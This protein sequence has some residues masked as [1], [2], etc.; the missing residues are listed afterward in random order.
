MPLASQPR[1]EDLREARPQNTQAQRPDA[2][3]TFA[4]PNARRPQLFERPLA[5]ASD[6]RPR[7]QGGHAAH[8]GHGAHGGARPHAKSGGA[9]KPGGFKPGGSSSGGSKSGGFKPG[10]GARGGGAGVRGRRPTR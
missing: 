6:D 3:R 10:S 5:E 8:G 4:G 7:T 1:R 9:K 2:P